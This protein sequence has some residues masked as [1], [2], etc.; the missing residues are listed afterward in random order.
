MYIK[1]E[2]NLNTFEAW[3][4]AVDTL[5]RIRNAGKCEE[6]EACLEDLYPDGMTDTELN[7]LLWF[8][9]DSVF[10]WVGLRTE[11]QVQIELD[12]AKCQLSDL[13]EELEDLLADYDGECIGIADWERKE[14]WEET[15]KDDVEDL[16]Q[17]IADAE[18]AV[19][20]LEEEYADF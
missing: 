14:I 15:Y 5:D 6:L 2:L 12:E 8:D 20:E 11:S 10:E 18:E 7:D 13:R 4:G 17:Q 3:S 9:A 19:E 1:S 16:K